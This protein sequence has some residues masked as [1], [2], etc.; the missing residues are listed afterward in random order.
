LDV[1]DQV[2]SEDTLRAFIQ[3]TPT[4]EDSDNLKQYI[5]CAPE[6]Y[7]RLGDA[8]KFFPLYSRH[9]KTETENDQLSL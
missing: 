9:S 4:K 6:I 1:Q 7:K 2:F 5:N 8:E 3:V